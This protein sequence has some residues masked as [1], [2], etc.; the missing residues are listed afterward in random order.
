MLHWCVETLD[1][2]LTA[3][4]NINVEA[5]NYISPPFSQPEYKFHV[6]RLSLT[7]YKIWTSCGYRR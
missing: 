7:G 4:L 3:A 1:L 6:N 5:V 2:L